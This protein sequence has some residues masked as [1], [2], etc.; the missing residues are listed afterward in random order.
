[1][2]DTKGVCLSLAGKKRALETLRHHRLIETFL[3]EILDYLI[4][5][6]HNEAERLEHYISESSEKLDPE[7]VPESAE[8][9]EGWRE[10]G[11]IRDNHQDKRPYSRYHACLAFK[12]F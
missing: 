3:Y 8:S 5:E 1:M 12:R 9:S 10:H 2:R 4:E 6:I 7:R 11:R